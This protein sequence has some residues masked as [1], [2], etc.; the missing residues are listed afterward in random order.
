MLS[1]DVILQYIFIIIFFLSCVCSVECSDGVFRERSGVLSSVDFPSPYPKSSDCLYQ[2]EVDP[3]FRVR[4]QFDPRFDVEDHPDVSCPYDHVKVRITAP[5]QTLGRCARLVN[6]RLT[7]VRLKQAAATSDRS[8]AIELQEI[9]RP[10]ATS[11]PSSSTATTQEKTPAG[12]SR[13]QRRVDNTHTSCQPAA[14]FTK[15]TFFSNA[16]ILSCQEVSV[17]YP[18]PRPMP[19]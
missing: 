5:V 2:I 3:G 19:C 17:R 14:L 6:Q 8:A 12:G 1:H 9:F 16:F 4:L 18:K 7:C 10:T 15:K 13:T 11:P